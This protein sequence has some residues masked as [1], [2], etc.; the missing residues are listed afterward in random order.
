MISERVGLGGQL[1]QIRQQLGLSLQGVQAKYGIPAVVVGAYERGDRAAVSHRLFELLAAYGYTLAVV[2][3]DVRLVGT[4][5]TSTD[6]LDYGVSVGSLWLPA[7]SDSDARALAHTTGGVAG[8]RV[9]SQSDPIPLDDL[10][11][12]VGQGG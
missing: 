4:L 3:P 8:Y 1:R 5:T 2:G 11:D 10:T 6:R 12:G 7:G 9:V